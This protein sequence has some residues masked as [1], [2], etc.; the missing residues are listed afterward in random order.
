MKLV[1]KYDPILSTPTEKFDFDNPQMDPIELF[2]NL[3]DAMVANRGMGLAAPQVGIPL[4]VFVIG[5]PDDPDNI[6]PVFNPKIVSHDGEV[7]EEE[8]CLSFPGLFVKVTRP[9]IVR[10]RYTTQHGGD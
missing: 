5:H 4:S 2:E 10:A 6:I 3:R 1:E 7:S 8:G 9:A